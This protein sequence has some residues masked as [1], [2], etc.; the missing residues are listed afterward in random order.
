MRI[1]QAGRAGHLTTTRRSG[2]AASAGGFQVPSGDG[3]QEA[4]RAGTPSQVSGIDSI[5]SLQEVPDSLSPRKKA[6]KK[7]HDML[8]VLEKMKIELLTGQISRSRGEAL[9]RMLETKS[10]LED[11]SV[12]SVLAEIELRARVELAKLGLQ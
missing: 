4:S 2:R 12:T 1:Q 5:L 11:E 8:D 9:L 6:L 10:E 3:S 7:G